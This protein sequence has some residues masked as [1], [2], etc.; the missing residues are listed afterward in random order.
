MNSKSWYFT[1]MNPVNKIR[2]FRVEKRILVILGIG[3]IFFAS[4]LA[5]FGNQYF[6]LFYER[7]YLQAEVRSLKVQVVALQQKLSPASV[8]GL[9]LRIDELRVIRQPKKAGFAARFRL[10]QQGPQDIPYSGTLAMVARNGS[11]KNP[12]YRAIPDM[13][14]EKGV[15]RHPE[16]GKPFEVKG[17]KFVE[18]LFDSSPEEVFHTLTV[19]VY[20]PQGRLLLQ[21]STEIPNP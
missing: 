20:S 21:Q 17:K 11:E 9:P 8:R 4:A 5:F 6:T 1:V 3:G 15:P 2:T 13:P 19:Y 18:A 7:A 16:K 12:L 10:I 14:L